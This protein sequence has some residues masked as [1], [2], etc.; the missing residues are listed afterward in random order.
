MALLYF[1]LAFAGIF[2]GCV[3]IAA[4]LEMHWNG[5]IA[6]LVGV[7][8]LSLG[9]R[10]LGR[11]ES[12]TPEDDTRDHNGPWT[13]EDFQNP[14]IVIPS[15]GI[16]LHGLTNHIDV[17]PDG[18]GFVVGYGDY[19]SPIQI[20]ADIELLPHGQQLALA[21]QASPGT[22]AADPKVV[23]HQNVSG[24]LEDDF[25]RYECRI[26][27]SPANVLA[28]RATKFVWTGAAERLAVHVAPS[29]NAIEAVRQR[30]AELA[31]EK[32]EAHQRLHAVR[33]Q[34]SAAEKGSAE[35]AALS[36]ELNRL[37]SLLYG[38]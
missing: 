24:F 16:S 13:A 14:H 28:L 12:T 17:N 22:D 25:M 21:L 1:K 23:D 36:A 15:K 11:S 26:R 34:L 3:M 20:T 7:G 35:A 9:I 31:R 5:A 19:Y 30:R 2:G 6:I 33:H 10:D 37:L 8:A 18:S 29:A 32:F 27:V 38:H 4:G